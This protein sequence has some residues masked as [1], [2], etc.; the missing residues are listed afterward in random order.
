MPLYERLL[1]TSWQC[2][3]LPYVSPG[4]PENSYLFRKIGGGPYCPNGEEPSDPMP[5]VGTLTD[6]QIDMVRRWIE[7]GAP[8]DGP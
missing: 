8:Y 3:D 4:D 2:D 6:D 5:Q 1:S 7:A